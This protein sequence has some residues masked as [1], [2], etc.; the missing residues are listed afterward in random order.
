MNL[1]DIA[2]VFSTDLYANLGLTRSDIQFMIDKISFFIG[3]V[4]NPFLLNK[5]DESFEGAVRKE[6]SAELQRTFDNY[7]N[8]FEYLST[9]SKR[10]F[11]VADGLQRLYEIYGLFE[12]TL[13]HYKFLR[14]NK[15]SL[16]NFC[17]AELWDQ[18]C[19]TFGDG[20][21][22]LPLFGYCDGFQSGNP[23][24]TY[25]NEGSLE[26]FYV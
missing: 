7:R 16:Q 8:P 19:K 24:G 17:Q 15:Y 23:L 12:A 26:T 3:E 25:A 20:K 6:V 22:V 9:E 5:L 2:T 1:E 13:D 10:L 18:I 11:P 4:Y 21:I 14:A